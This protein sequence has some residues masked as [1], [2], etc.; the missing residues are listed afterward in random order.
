MIAR[1]RYG[2]M[3]PE[4]RIA[5]KDLSREILLRDSIWGL[6]NSRQEPTFWAATGRIDG[7]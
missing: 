4:L 2:F 6:A 3:K 7:R 1:K 5:G